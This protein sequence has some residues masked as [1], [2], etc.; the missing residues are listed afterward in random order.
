MS[1]ELDPVETERLRAAFAAAADV[2]PAA[3][4]C[5]PPER[6]WE[7]ATGELDPA[8][9]GDVVEH[10]AACPQCAESWRLATA[11]AAEEAGGVRDLA[12]T[13]GSPR[14][15]GRAFAWRPWL[16]A[17][18]AVAAVAVGL[19]WVVPELVGPAP[20]TDAP[21][22]REA[23]PEAGAIRSALPADRALSRRAPV[24]VWSPV[25]TPGT[26]YD[27]DVTTEELVPVAEAR[28]LEEASFQLPAGALDALPAGTRLLWRV[29]AE[30][31][32]GE[33]VRSPTFVTPVGP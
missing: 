32:S 14:A 25:E 33:V 3:E 13:A 23:A 8:A 7:A 17:A 6:L 19:V 27:I 26:T 10:L 29:T 22:Y 4:P 11:F 30:T 21:V 18:A 5:P 16:A 31:P 24:L 28:G 1:I 9:T 20:A 15:A 2:V 12:A